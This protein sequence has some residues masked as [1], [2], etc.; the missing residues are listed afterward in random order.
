MQFQ[1]RV[2]SL[3]RYRTCC[4]NSEHTRCLGTEPVS[5]TK[6][7]RCLGTDYPAPIRSTLWG[8]IQRLLSHPRVGMQAYSLHRCN[9]FC[10]ISGYNRCVCTVPAA[11][12]PSLFIAEALYIRRHPKYVYTRCLATITPAPTRNICIPCSISFVLHR[13]QKY[14][15]TLCHNNSWILVKCAKKI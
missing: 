3:P 2:Y 13:R 5:P 10:A 11:P 9:S 1:P 14:T 8:Q 4:A 6:Y 15:H 7:F 12:F